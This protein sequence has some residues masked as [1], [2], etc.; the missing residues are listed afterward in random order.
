MLGRSRLFP[1]LQCWVPSV[2]LRTPSADDERWLHHTIGG[3]EYLFGQPITFTPFASAKP[4]S[5]RCTFCSETLQHRDSNLLSA[6]IRPQADYFDGLRRALEELKHLPLSF[7]LSGLENTDDASWLLRLLDQL[8]CFAATGGT[9]EERVLYTNAAGLCR[10]TTGDVL[11]PRLA[12]FN[13]TRAEMSRHYYSG[14]INQRIMRFRAGQPIVHQDVYDATVRDVLEH[15]P[16]R[17]VCIVQRGGVD[18]AAAV[19]RYIS[20]ARSLGVTDI[21]FRELSRLGGLYRPNKTMITIEQTRFSIE[22]LI[23]DCLA[24]EEFC[25]MTQ[26]LHCTAGYYFWN[27]GILFADD[28][29]V[30]FET[31]DYTEMKSLHR[32]GRVYKLIY[33]ANGNLCGDWDPEKQ[34]LLR[35][36][37]A[38]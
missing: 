2:A 11:L 34:I 8:D 20:W 24:N 16:V 28:V 22:D 33:H 12:Q 35:T 14:E 23:E 9:V 17:L 29:R 32:S 5:A 10:E 25:G 37:A 21:V 36:S 7:S 18:S 19:L 6:S 26:P 31:S 1:R 27:L 30:T 13:L 15:V 38:E 3:I 4:C